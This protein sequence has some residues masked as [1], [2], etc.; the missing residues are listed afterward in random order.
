MVKLYKFQKILNFKLKLTPVDYLD[1]QSRIL[2]EHAYE[3]ITDAGISP[4]SL[5]GSKTGVFIGCCAMDSDFFI[6]H[7]PSNKDGLDLSSSSRALLSNRISF[8]LDLKGTSFTVDTACS[9]SAFAFDLAFKAI[10]NGEIE[11]A[12]VGGTNLL[13]HPDTS[14]QFKRVGL[15][16]QDGTCRS[17]DINASGYCRAEAINMLFLQKLTDA[18][19]VYAHVLHTRTNEDGFKNEGMMFPS[20]VNQIKLLEEFYSEIGIDPATIDYVEAHS[21]GTRVKFDSD[22]S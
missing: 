5:Q 21:A 9:S 14:L 18:K 4:K 16:S 10:K 7:A 22:L 11:A 8:A 19:R 12:L 17:F 2:L 6:V 1:P 13:L 3:C 15:L 20:C